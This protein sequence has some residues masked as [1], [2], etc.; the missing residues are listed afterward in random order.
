MKNILFSICA[1]ALFVAGYVSA[2]HA[3][4]EIQNPNQ[5]MESNVDFD[6][7]D[8]GLTDNQSPHPMCG[9]HYHSHISSVD[10][11]NVSFVKAPGKQFVQLF[12]IARPSYIY[13]I[14]RPPRI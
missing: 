13:G 11:M 10:F 12:Q 8:D 4:V 3:H 5:Y 6:N 1:I 7:A 9:I 2:A 14:K